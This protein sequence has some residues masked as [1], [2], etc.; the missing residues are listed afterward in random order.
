MTKQDRGTRGKNG[1][2]RVS[3]APASKKRS[4]VNPD[5][6]DSDGDEIQPRA[7]KLTKTQAWKEVLGP[8][9]GSKKLRAHQLSFIQRK[10]I[11]NMSHPNYVTTGFERYV[12]YSLIPIPRLL[13]TEKTLGVS[14][15]GCL[16]MRYSNTTS[17][18]K[19]E[20]HRL[21]RP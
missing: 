11:E 6:S 2:G 19:K 14:S 3:K 9:S 15:R 5:N 10:G 1:D 8:N 4:A 16:K 17:I 20:T 7:R 13:S 21:L 18:L 12:P